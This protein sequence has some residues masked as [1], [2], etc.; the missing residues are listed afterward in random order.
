[1]HETII[2]TVLMYKSDLNTT[3]IAPKI[4]RKIPKTNYPVASYIL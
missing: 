4:V 1:M 2:L 3:M